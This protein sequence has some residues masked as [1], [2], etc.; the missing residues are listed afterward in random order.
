MSGAIIIDSVPL[1]CDQPC[2]SRETAQWLHVDV[3]GAEAAAELKKVAP[4]LEDTVIEALCAEDTRPHFETFGL[5]YLVI[6][7]GVNLNPGE[8]YEDMVSLR[9]WTDGRRVISAERRPVQAA[10]RLLSKV[11]SADKPLQA[12]EVIV[13]LTMSIVANMR[14]PFAS[15]FDEID[16]LELEAL[17]TASA[18]ERTALIDIR[19]RTLI[20][21]RYVSPLQ[22]A[23]S[24]LEETAEDW[25]DSKQIRRLRQAENTLM[26][27]L[28]DLNAARERLKY[29]Q[30]EVLAG[31]TDKAN[32]NMYRLSIVAAIFLPL[33]FLTGLLGINVAGIP[34]AE[35]QTAFWWVVGGCG[36]VILAQILYFRRGDWF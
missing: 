25:P 17:E 7:R 4:Y 6:L 35:V 1:A 33:S 11:A 34:G 36:A 28:E 24:A 16:A 29:L 10:R 21:H 30:D 31:L 8:K 5:E 23:I 26:R 14:Q 20:L 13:R 32:K 19:R 15:F 12:Q 18:Q 22:Q 2:T 27:H 9:V 3:E